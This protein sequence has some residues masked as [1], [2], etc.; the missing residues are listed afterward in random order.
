MYLHEGRILPDDGEGEVRMGGW[1]RVESLRVAEGVVL[2]RVQPRR[3]LPP[4]AGELRVVIQCSS[5]R[6]VMR[7]S[8]LS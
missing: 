4:V 6:M 1:Q 8:A 3:V 7:I 2:Q 5:V